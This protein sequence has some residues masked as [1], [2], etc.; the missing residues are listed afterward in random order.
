[1]LV[2]G[3]ER[4]GV[5]KRELIIYV[6]VIMGS[7]LRKRHWNK[8]WAGTREEVCEYQRKVLRW[9]KQQ[10]QRP[11]DRILSSVFWEYEEDWWLMWI[12]QG[13]KRG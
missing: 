9:K 6:S 11:W 2:K 4:D 1:M 3:W 10:V 13:G 12:D 7:F 8:D 5:A